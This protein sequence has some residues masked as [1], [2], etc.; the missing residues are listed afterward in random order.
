M[1]DE[2]VRPEA[3]A[4]PDPAPEPAAA[5]PPN[6]AT[7]PPAS[8]AIESRPP[9]E[10]LA[11]SADL[12]LPP[13]LPEGAPLPPPPP[14]P[15][16]VPPA[17][18]P[19]RF[20]GRTDE[21]F[22]IWI[23]NTLLTLLTLGIFFAWAKVRKRRYLRGSTELLGHRFDYRAN[24]VRLLLGHIV[25]LILFLGYSLFGVVY[26]AVR[27]GVI[28]LAI[29]LLPWIVVRSF[30]FNAHNTVYRGLR[31]RFNPSLS[32]ALKVYLLE[33][34]LI[35]VT[36]GL[37]YPAWQ[38]SKR[39]YAVS[40]HRLGDAY[41]RFDATSGHF[42]ATYLAAGAIL[43]GA[44]MVGGVIIALFLARNPGTQPTLVQLTPFF[45]I[46]AF[47]FFVSR[48]LTYAMLFNHVWNHTR[49]DEHRFRAH[50]HVGHWLGLQLVNLGAILISAGLLYPWALIRAQTYAASC[51]EFVPSGSVENISRVGSSAG[52]A[53]GDMAAE[54]IGLDFGL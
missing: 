39:D 14:P 11:P 24:P 51:L 46:Y 18:H 23:V 32:A 6:P 53:T 50:L 19:L 13:L 1:S 49:I 42:Y 10:S 15:P 7:T 44:L 45:L 29:V 48:H 22:R 2:P 36:L 41:F 12:S 47:G 27:F 5:P 4:V 35:G 40:N 54:F 28:A 52:S 30:S 17:A 38:R 31:F 43:F 33:P 26:P 21:Y 16:P 3:S 37:Y 25:V 20:H 34:L 8:S 9:P